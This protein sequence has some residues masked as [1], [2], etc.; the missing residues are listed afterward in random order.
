MQH[1]ENFPHSKPAVED[2][3]SAA[4]LIEIL[5]K[6]QYDRVQYSDYHDF[7]IVFLRKLIIW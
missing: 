7:F 4:E 5:L 2:S 6:S 3:V 1:E